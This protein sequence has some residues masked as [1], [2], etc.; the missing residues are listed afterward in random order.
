M[1]HLKFKKGNLL[2]IW[3][4]CLFNILRWPLNFDPVGY[5]VSG[6]TDY[7][8]IQLCWI[9]WISGLTGYPDI[10]LLGLAGYP[11]SPIIRLSSFWISW[12][13]G[14]TDDPDIQLFGLAGYPGQISSIRCIPVYPYI[15]FYLIYHSLSSCN[16][17]GCGS[18]SG[19]GSGLDPDSV[20]L[21][22]RIRI[23]IGNPD[24]DPGARK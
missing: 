9:S 13:F 21:W 2:Y 18:G 3:F 8:D 12:I 5:P 20:T 22:I 17:Q 16:S 1:L 7:P 4:L 10:Q 6:L 19:S 11:A 24:Q 23:R 15:C 14:L